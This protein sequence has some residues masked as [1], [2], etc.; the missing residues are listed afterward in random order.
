MCVAF[1]IYIR[2]KLTTNSLFCCFYKTHY[3]NTVYSLRNRVNYVVQCF[4][5]ILIAKKEMVDGNEI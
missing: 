3:N 2:L 1:F 5:E 4:L